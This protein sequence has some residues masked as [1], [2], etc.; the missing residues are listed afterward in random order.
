VAEGSGQGAGSEGSSRGPGWQPSFELLESKLHPP[1]PGQGIVPRTALLERLLTMPVAR[2]VCL[3]APS[4]YGKTTLLAQWAE[5]RRGRT[6][7]VTLDRH[8]NDPVVLLRYLAVALDRVDPI[9]PGLQRL[10]ESPGAAVPASLVSRFVAGLSSLRQ[11]VTIVLDNLELLVNQE[12]LDAVAE[13]GLRLPAG[14]RVGLAS[15]ARPSLPSAL[16]HPVGQMVEV[17]AEELAMDE[18]E[19][20]AVLER[21][22]VRSSDAE[23]AELLELTEGWPVGVYLA[24]SAVAGEGRHASARTAASGNG[25]PAAGEPAAGEPPTGLLGRLS[26]STVTF[27]TR[28]AVLDELSGPLCDAV[29]QM[30]GSDRVLESLAGSKLL[31]AELEHP[32]RWYRYHQ[33]LREMLLAELEHREPELVGELH[34]RAAAWYED[35]GRPEPAVDHGQAAGDGDRVARLVAALAFGAYAGGRIQTARGWLRWFEDH[36]LVERYPRIAV[37]GAQLEALLG[38]A[39]SAE[40]WAAGAERGLER[41]PAD[42][43][44]DASMALLRTLLCRDGMAAMRADAAA[45][46]QGLAGDS[47]WQVT[48][49]LM[50]GISLLL[51]GQPDRA[52]PILGRVVEL[53]GQHGAAPAASAALAERATVAME[54][55]QWEQASRLAGRAV[56]VVRAGRLEGYPMA[57]FIHA[58]A[59][60]TVLHQGDGGRARDH[61]TRATNLR[62]LLTSAMPHRS[63][64]TLTEMARAYLALDDVAGARAVL[65]QAGEIIQQRPSLGVLPGQVGGLKRV[66]DELGQGTVGASSLTAAELRLLPLLSTHLSLLEIGERLHLS[67]N[68]VKTHAISIYRKLGVSS[69]SEAMRRVRELGLLDRDA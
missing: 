3:A 55:G 57:A 15:R 14:S 12:C 62:P 64:Q 41:G 27:L 13:V 28:T 56:A 8:D 24:S 67:R 50:E 10:L 66:A 52:D 51:D 2:L 63:V 46:S 26:A 48:A 47:P 5:R 6:A 40:R 39:S 61:L 22:G 69:R 17:G 44:L 25:Q 23:V 29:L 1:R 42:A 53:A 54:R 68:T 18:G 16:T 9:D 45:A 19:V 37:L 20:R 32:G 21:A 34:R 59:A 4:G 30:R 65:R 33:V 58:V 31:L 60:R 36:G 49:L 11:P 7:W 38:D 35:S 43:T